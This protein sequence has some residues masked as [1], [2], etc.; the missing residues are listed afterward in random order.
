MRRTSSRPFV[1]VHP[2]GRGDNVRER[3]AREFPDGSPPRA[4]GQSDRAC[5]SRHDSRFTP[6]GVGTIRSTSARSRS[7]T[8]HPHG[9]GDNA[10]ARDAMS[11]NAW[12]TPTGVG[13][14]SSAAA[15]ALHSSVHPHG[16]GDNLHSLGSYH[17]S[18]GSPPRAW[19]QCRSDARR[20]GDPRFTPTG[21]GTIT[22]PIAPLMI[23]AVHPHGRGDNFCCSAASQHIIG[24]PPRAWGQ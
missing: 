22:S 2:H 6:T 8:V 9:R 24:S 4:W 5:T 14:I 10:A 20:V 17:S 7:A 13:T 21:V 16:R 11:L 1:A 12:F 3:V 18:D 23:H 19:G 15:G